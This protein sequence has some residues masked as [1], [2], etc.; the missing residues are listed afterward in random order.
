MPGTQPL[1]S[2]VPAFRPSDPCPTRAEDPAARPAEP[3]LRSISSTAELLRR[4]SRPPNYA[5]ENR[6][7]VALA[8]QLAVSPEGILQELADTALNLCRAH[9]AGLSLLEKEDQRKN[10]HWRAIAGQWAAHRGGGTAAP[11]DAPRL[12]FFVRR[13]G[14]RTPLKSVRVNSTCNALGIDLPRRR[15]IGA[16]CPVLRGRTASGQARRRGTVLPP[17]SSSAAGRECAP[18]RLPVQT[19]VETIEMRDDPHRRAA[20]TGER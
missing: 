19:I 16:R 15:L 17:G 4:P 5:A 12:A 1:Q 2:P 9:S 10:F 6:S 13:A 3:E 18:P 8:R 11:E 7:L 14:A 20:R